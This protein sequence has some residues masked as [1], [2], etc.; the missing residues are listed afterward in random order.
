MQRRIRIGLRRQPMHWGRGDDETH[1]V[2]ADARDDE[3]RQQQQAH[4]A[5]GHGPRQ[6]GRAG[7]PARPAGARAPAR[8]R[9]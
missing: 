3:E 4:G 1:A 7:G 8:A 9:G 5:A 2:G 6:A